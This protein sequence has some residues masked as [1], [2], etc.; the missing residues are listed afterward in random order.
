MATEENR[1]MRYDMIDPNNRYVSHVI[2]P[3]P[4]EDMFV[5]YNN[6][7]AEPLMYLHPKIKKN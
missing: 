6:L 1:V 3:H 4:V 7:N 5:F 2:F